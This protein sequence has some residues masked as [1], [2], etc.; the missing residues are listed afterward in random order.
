MI[1][2]MSRRACFNSVNNLTLDGVI[3]VF[4]S[5]LF[6]ITAASLLVGGTA[7]S[8]EIYKW[9]DADGDVHYGDRPIG[10]DVE[11]L[12]M[13]SNSNTDNDAVRASVEARHD[14]EAAR[15]ES[16]SKRDEADQAAADARAEAAQ[17]GVKCQESRTRMQTYLQSRRLYQQDDAGER[18][19]LDEDQT[20]QARADAQEMIQKYCD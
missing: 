10:T 11:R 9:T 4:R 1:T 14:R 18:V 20:M 16:R 3:P 19:Y 7:L 6:V 15:S 13:T 12:H 5:A 2:Q 8:G 17:R